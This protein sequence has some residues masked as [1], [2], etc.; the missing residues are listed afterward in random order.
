MLHKIILLLLL[1]FTQATNAKVVS[2]ELQKCMTQA[3]LTSHHTKNSL[4]AKRI[5]QGDTA[6]DKEFRVLMDHSVP[7]PYT[8]HTRAHSIQEAREMSRGKNGTAQY[9]PGV[10]REHLERAALLNRDG[11]YRHFGDEN[12]GGKGGTFYK[13]VKFDKVIGFEGG[14]ETQWMRVEWSSGQYHGHPIS[15]ERLHAQ[16]ASC[17]K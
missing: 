10:Q 17:L 12:A 8:K 6:I 5:G 9:L 11:V 7:A 13:Y 3:L 14:N 4:N 2:E 1:V 16:C 15:L